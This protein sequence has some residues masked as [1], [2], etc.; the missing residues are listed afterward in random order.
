[1]WTLVSWKTVLLLFALVNW[2]SLPFAW[3]YRV[4]YYI[5]RH[6]RRDPVKLLKLG[7]QPVDAR[8]RP[9]HPIFAAASITSYTS[10]LETDYN[11]H[12]SNSTYYADMDISRTSV[13]TQLYTPGA[14]IVSREL[15]VELAAA[16]KAE[17]K[18]APKK[19]L[20]MYIALGA[21]FCSF[22]RELKPLRR[23]E[24]RSQVA[25]WDE[26]WLY[27]VTYFLQSAR[28]GA[29]PTLAA[30]GV[31]KYCFKKGRLTVP[32]ERVARASG[33]L[34]PRPDGVSTPVPPVSSTPTTNGLSSALDETKLELIE[35]GKKVE[36]RVLE[37]QR[38]KNIDSW[39][40]NVWT[41][42]R[43]DEHRKRG[44]EM[45]Q[46]FLTLDNKLLEDWNQA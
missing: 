33:L 24:M 41:W 44:L 30:V 19:K 28:K 10:L 6:L 23:F 16:A 29:E 11:M 7:P 36:P 43:I 32:V 14:D 26:K 4:F 8:G 40:P 45:L 39:D 9:T 13:V 35:I 27:V 46:G 25:A 38:Q 22:K 42:E 12:K 1:M 2:K 34:P 21:A 37:Q 5:F 17:G 31:S 20:P 18:P 3:T 15:D